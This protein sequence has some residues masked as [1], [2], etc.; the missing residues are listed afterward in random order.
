MR[1]LS[2]LTSSANWIGRFFDWWFTELSGMVPAGLRRFLV[3]G[4]RLLAVYIEE[5]RILLRRWEGRKYRDLG[6]DHQEQAGEDLG[7]KL[8]HLRRKGAE[9]VLC[10][11]RHHALNK[12][13]KLPAL[14][15]LELRRALYYQIDRQTPFPAADTYFDSSL[16]GNEDGHTDVLL[17]AV[18]KKTVDRELARFAGQDIIFDRIAIGDGSDD[19]PPLLDLKPG[20]DERE[21]RR[22]LGRIVNFAA[23]A[24]ACGLLVATGHH[25]FSERRAAA[26]TLAARVAEARNAANEAADLEQQ[27]V[28]LRSNLTFLSDKKRNQPMS[29]SVLHELTRIL[30]DHTW[31]SELRRQ[32]RDIH[33]AGYSAAAA[34]LIA[35][36][37]GSQMF[38]EPRFQSPVTLDAASGKERFNLTCRL[39]GPPQKGAP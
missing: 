21:V 31:L 12:E 36:I 14:A 9:L 4:P 15:P 34:D 22:D 16:I 37:E 38:I 1:L 8:S 33:V 7:N 32:D 5:E 6:P 25:A 13:L 18:P 39:A 3:P 2:L 27:I 17:V 24:A 35:V 20:L 19:E 28:D 26:E 23:T 30:P 11:P 10:L 29:L